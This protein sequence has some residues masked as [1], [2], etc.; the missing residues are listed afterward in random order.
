[1]S[2]KMKSNVAIVGESGHR[3]EMCQKRMVL[4]DNTTYNHE[5]QVQAELSAITKRLV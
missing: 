5:M 1:M 4:E 2:L 3:A